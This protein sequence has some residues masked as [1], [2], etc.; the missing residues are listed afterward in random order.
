MFEI[1][2]MEK[3]A[4][5][6][7]VDLLAKVIFSFTPDIVMSPLALPRNLLEPWINELISQCHTSVMCN[8]LEQLRNRPT[9]EE[10]WPDTWQQGL[11]KGKQR[12]L[13]L[14]KIRQDTYTINEILKQDNKIY[15][16][17]QNIRS[18]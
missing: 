3:L 13:Q 9:F 18:D 8:M 6:Y 17:W 12:I 14:E 16:W 15:E 2:K 4:Q 5:Q 11:I 10:Q 7:D 1:L